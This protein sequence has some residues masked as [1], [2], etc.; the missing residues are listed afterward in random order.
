MF[1]KQVKPNHVTLSPPSSPKKKQ[2]SL[3]IAGFPMA[4]L[5]HSILNLDLKLVYSKA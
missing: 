4:Q 1:C 5:N 3:A 2:P